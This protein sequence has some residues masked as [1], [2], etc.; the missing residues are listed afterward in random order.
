MTD[1]S[2]LP[3]RLWAVSRRRALKSLLAIAAVALATFATATSHAND[4]VFVL[5]AGGVSQV[6]RVQVR[7]EPPAVGPAAALP[8]TFDSGTSATFTDLVVLPGGHLMGTDASGRGLAIFDA[9]GHQTDELAG[10]GQLPPLQSAVAAS[11]LG[12]NQPER[13][14]LTDNSVRRVQVYDLVDERYLFSERFLLSNTPG[15]MVRA[16]LLPSNRAAVLLNWPSLSTSALLVI[17]LDTPPV[18]DAAILSSTSPDFPGAALISDLYPAQD[19]T[20]DIDGR[21][22]IT[23]RETLFVVDAQGGI[24]DEIGV[25]ESGAAGGVFQSARWLPTGLI[26]A[27]T[28]QP[29]LWTTPHTN[30]RVHLFDPAEPSPLLASSAALNAAPL[31]LELQSGQGGTGTVDFFADLFDDDGDLS[32]LSVSDG[33]SLAP[34]EIPRGS[35]AFF[36]ATLTYD[37]PS[38]LRLRRL[39]F[40][41]RQGACDAEDAPDPTD[42]WL[43]L[44]NIDLDTGDSFEVDQVLTPTDRPLGEWCGQL[45]ATA[46]DGEQAPLG[47]PLNFTFVPPDD[48]GE[49]ITVEDLATFDSDAGHQA[50]T[51]FSIDDDPDQ[52]GC[53]CSTSPTPPVSLWILLA[54]ALFLIGRRDTAAPPAGPS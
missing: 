18:I 53:G 37:G 10:P 5:T 30:H 33:P 47:A 26:L 42:P 6:E 9:Q 1:P 31:R 40:R 16:V 15:D 39:E 41:I 44:Q 38:L 49:V 2:T 25:E 35:S 23:S 13:V 21:L 29:G 54:M 17:T 7:Y 20:A 51:G 19:L 14:L 48:Q 8:L 4:P 11:Y 43:S 22:L 34:R 50:D 27:A 36:G 3:Q 52:G 46:R 12:P 32:A 28:R 24:L 45:L